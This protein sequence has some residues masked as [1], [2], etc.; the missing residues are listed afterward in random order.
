MCFNETTLSELL[1]GFWMGADYQKDQAMTDSLEFSDL[2]PTSQERGE[3]L[4]IELMIDHD[5]VIKPS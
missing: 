3:G 4:A 1:D 2:S 5:C